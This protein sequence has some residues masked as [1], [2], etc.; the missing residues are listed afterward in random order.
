[1]AAVIPTVYFI[2]V[3]IFYSLKSLVKPIPVNDES[4]L[5]KTVRSLPHEYRILI[6]EKKITNAFATGV[7]PFTKVI[8]IG[9]ELL[10]AF[11]ELEIE[12]VISHEVGHL[13]FN[14]LSKMYFVNLI[15]TLFVVIF[16]QILIAPSFGNS[17]FFVLL[18]GIYY[19][20]FLGAG[21]LII[22]GQFQKKYEKEADR[23]AA[24]IVGKE[25]FIQTLISLNNL[26]DKKMEKWS[27]NY[28]TLNERISNVKNL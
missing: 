10:N 23:Y 24:T 1:M 19:G 3:P 18:I 28:P 25:T 8:L 5:K 27:W 9:R 7:L 14:H 6:V 22:S 12:A 2:I 20:I 13:K 17:S 4:F 26:A 11:S 15:W 16:F 21:L